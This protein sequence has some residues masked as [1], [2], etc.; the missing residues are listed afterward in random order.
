MKT[1]MYNDKTT[2]EEDLANSL[3][4]IIHLRRLSNGRIVVDSIHEVIKNEIDEEDLHM[5]DPDKENLFHRLAVK[6]IF[7]MLMGHQYTLRPV[8][9][10]DNCRNDWIFIN[11]PSD[12][13]IS[14]MMRYADGDLVSQVM[15][16]KAW[17]N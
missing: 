6:Y 14:K 12:K 13:Y 15:E 7:D 9:Q 2:A 4:L 11:R 1:S 10:F 17:I 5:N 8:V 3:D 16:D